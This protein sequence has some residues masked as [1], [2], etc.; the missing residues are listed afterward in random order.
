MTTVQKT[1]V[2]KDVSA[3]MG[4]PDQTYMKQVL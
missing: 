2:V 4:I 3:A 1:R